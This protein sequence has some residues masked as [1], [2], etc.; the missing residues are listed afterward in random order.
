M[1]ACVDMRVCD[2][3][4]Q[5][6]PPSQKSQPV[7]KSKALAGDSAQSIGLSGVVGWLYFFHIFLPMVGWDARETQT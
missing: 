2:E 3:V 6:F 7:T 4:H 1:I 5:Q